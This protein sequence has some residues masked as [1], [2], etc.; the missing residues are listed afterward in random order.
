MISGPPSLSDLPLALTPR[1][2]RRD[3]IREPGNAEFGEVVRRFLPL[4]YGVSSALIPE[5]AESAEKVSA[6]VFETLAFRWKRIARK[7]PLAS[8][9][10]RTT[11]YAAA[12]ERSQ[13]GL[14]A[15]SQLSS[16]VLAQT[17]FKKLNS[18][19]QR[20]ADA[21]VLCAILGEQ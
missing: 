15:K 5:N 6:A 1:D 19:S 2:L 8:W 4:V 9:L 13:L 17:L 21:F 10:V 3:R 20:R 14:K 7:T 11:G 16:G 12:K 18:L